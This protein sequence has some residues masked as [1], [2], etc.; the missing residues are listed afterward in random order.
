MCTSARMLAGALS[1]LALAMPTWALAAPNERLDPARLFERAVN[2]GA[3]GDHS[4]ARTYLEPVLLYPRLSRGARARAYYLR[5]LLFYREGA[6]VS[7]AQDYRRALAFQ[8]T[9][10]QARTGLAWLHLKG[11]GVDRSAS[12]AGEL[13]RL[14]ARQGYQEAQYTLGLLLARGD[15]LQRDP[16]EA[17][18]WFET[19]A[20]SGHAEA[21]AL[22]GRLLMGTEESMAAVRARRLLERAVALDHA[23]ARLTLGR[24]L[25]ATDPGTARIRLTEAASTGNARAQA[26]LGRLLLHGAQ[27]LDADPE[28]GLLWLREAAKQGDSSAQTWLGW[29]F[30]TGLGTAADP[31]RALRWYERAAQRN[32]ATA[33]F[34]LSLLYREGRGTPVRP[35]LAR[36]WLERAADQGQFDARISLAWSLA[37]ADQAEARDAGRALILA[38]A[39]VAERENAHTLEVLAAA[40]AAGGRYREARVEQARALA[41]AEEVGD[42]EESLAALEARLAAYVEDRAWRE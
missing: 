18:Y 24:M 16:A 34:N 27:G 26:E 14:A 41:L 8:P 15:V 28:A 20:A 35:N 22:G 19:A 11:L 5:G 10:A 30:D 23:G 37:T 38:R 21:A 7:A 32:D 4:L 1:L 36:R 29:A 6:Y 42:T 25:L 9:L 39:V 33:Q 13:Y 31:E 12:R 3:S 17:I 2:V 40:L